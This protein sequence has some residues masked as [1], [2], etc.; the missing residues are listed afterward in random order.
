MPNKGAEAR[1]ERARLV[2]GVRVAVCGDLRTAC[3]KLR[4]L[5]VSQ[6]DKFDDAINVCFKLRGGEK[7][8]LML[9]YAPQGEGVVAQ[10]PYKCNDGG[11]WQSIPVK[12]L[13]EPACHSALVELESAVLAIGRGLQEA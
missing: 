5:G 11:E 3:T 12:L 10:M 13:N 4:D 7:Y 2:S 1:R 8:H 6:I 9:I